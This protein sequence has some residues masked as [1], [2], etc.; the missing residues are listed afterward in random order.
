MDDLQL[1]TLSVNGQHLAVPIP[2]QPRTQWMRIP[3]ATARAALKMRKG[4]GM[5]E[6]VIS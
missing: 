4:T 1:T 6:R 2:G 5:A 3:C